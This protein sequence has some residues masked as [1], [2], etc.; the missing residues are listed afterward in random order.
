MSELPDE[1]TVV[2]NDVD[3]GCAR[4]GSSTGWIDCWSCADGLA[5]DEDDDT[6]EPILVA[7]EWC[8]GRG[9]HDACLSGAEWCEANPL[10]GQEEV[11]R[12]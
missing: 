12:T 10:P 6:G 8:D 9:G 4:C 11:E 2:D 7:C 1:K 5:Y 3:R